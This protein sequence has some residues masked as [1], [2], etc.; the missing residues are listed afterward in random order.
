M[1]HISIPDDGGILSSLGTERFEGV[2][3][4]GGGLLIG[5][6]G[7]NQD[8]SRVRLPPIAHEMGALNPRC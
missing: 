1:H 8:P 3:V 6:A 2:T 7:R 4:V 5:E